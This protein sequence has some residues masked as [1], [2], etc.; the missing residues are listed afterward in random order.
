MAGSKV[1][2]GGKGGSQTNLLSIP[3]QAIEI[4]FDDGGY[5]RYEDINGTIYE[6]SGPTPREIQTNLTLDDMRR[7]AIG[8]GAMVLDLDQDD[9]DR[10]AERNAN[11]SREME[12]LLDQAY[13]SDK[14]FKRGSRMARIGNRKR[15]R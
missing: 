3:R 12:A 8:I 11:Y 13:V 15:S 4:T 2:R 5:Y 14:T 6:T 1:G 10:I 9:L 7:N